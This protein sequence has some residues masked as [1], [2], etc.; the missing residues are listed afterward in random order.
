MKKM[1][2]LAEISSSSGK[3]KGKAVCQHKKIKRPEQQHSHSKF[4]FPFS[5]DDDP[6]S[7][8]QSQSQSS[9]KQHMISFRSKNKETES[10]LHNQQPVPKLYR[11]VRQRQWG[12]WVA[13]IR[14]PHSRSRR[15]LGTFDNAHQAALAY[16][17]EAFKLRGNKARLNFPDLFIKDEKQIPA[18]SL[19]PCVEQEV[20]PLLNDLHG[21]SEQAGPCNDEGHSV[22]DTSES[23]FQYPAWE[24]L[25][26]GVSN[27]SQGG[28][29]FIWDN[30]EPSFFNP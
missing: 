4:V 1:A 13:E 30:F 24:S 2:D 27:A 22:F 18:P 7:M 10:H 16:D 15:W 23:L 8:S 14:L 12:K 26:D 3:N 9:K 29:S 21:S 11:G 28:S 17:H 20:K 19:E 5:L 6:Q 25:E